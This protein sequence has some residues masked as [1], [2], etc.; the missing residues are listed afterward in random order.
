MN[1]A[2]LQVYQTIRQQGTQKAIIDT[3]QTREEL[4]QV[5]NYHSYEKKLDALF[6]K[7][8]S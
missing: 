3:M 2:A 6:S 7:E 8:T 4:Y 5:L 1:A